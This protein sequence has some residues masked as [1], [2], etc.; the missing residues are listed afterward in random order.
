VAIKV[1]FAQHTIAATETIAAT[2]A[3]EAFLQEHPY[4]NIF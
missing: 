2:V 1:Y 4:I 3:I